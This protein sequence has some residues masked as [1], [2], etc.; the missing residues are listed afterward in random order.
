M[1]EEIHL[2]KLR[3]LT[4]PTVRPSSENRSGLGVIALIGR[5][6]ADARA[7]LAEWRRHAA[8]ERLIRIAAD[9]EASRSRLP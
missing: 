7:R 2:S 4:V 8:A 6:R 1:N 5:R 3:S 9:I